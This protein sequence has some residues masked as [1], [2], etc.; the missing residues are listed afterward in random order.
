MG[1][2]VQGCAEGDLGQNGPVTPGGCVEGMVVGRG[3]REGVGVNRR[4]GVGGSEGWVMLGQGTYSRMA[5]MGS[6]EV[7]MR[8]AAP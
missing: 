4:F 6:A 5:D 8:G 2:D 7:G 3:Q 1:E